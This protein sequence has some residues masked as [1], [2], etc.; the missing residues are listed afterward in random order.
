[1]F[2]KEVPSSWRYAQDPGYWK[3]LEFFKIFR[4]FDQKQIF[5]GFLK[6]KETLRWIRKETKVPIGL[7]TLFPLGFFHWTGSPFWGMISNRLLCRHHH[8]GFDLSWCN[9]VPDRTMNSPGRVYR[10]CVLGAIERER[11][12]AC[13]VDTHGNQLAK[14]ERGWFQLVNTDIV[15]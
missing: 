4:N 12:V 14:K 10:C 6:G 2:P 8:C 9:I 15:S 3:C 7:A 5:F 13:D 1:M 11:F